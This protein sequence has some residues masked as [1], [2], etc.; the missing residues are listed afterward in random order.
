[1]YYKSLSLLGL[2]GYLET[3]RMLKVLSRPAPG[4]WNASKIDSNEWLK[5]SD[6]N[7]APGVQ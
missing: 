5:V 7:A 6:S 3:L 4:I 1:M 2:Y